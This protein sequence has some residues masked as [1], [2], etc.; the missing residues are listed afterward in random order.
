MITSMETITITIPKKMLSSRYGM[1][2]LVLVE[3]KE[4]TQKARRRW[5]IEDAL[6]ASR[7]ARREWKQGTTRQIGSLRELM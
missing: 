4:L 2:Q 6:E 3:P 5:E 1:R 7:S